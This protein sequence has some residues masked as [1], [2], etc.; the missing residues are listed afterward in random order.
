MSDEELDSVAIMGLEIAG[1][2]VSEVYSPGR[3]CALASSF[4][5]KPGI[6]AS[7]TEQ[8]P[9]GSYWDFERDEDVREWF[10]LLERDDPF[11]LVG[12]PPCEQ[13]SQLQDLMKCKRSPEDRE[14]ALRKARRHLWVACESYKRQLARG[15]HFLHE[16]PWGAGSWEED[17][18]REVLSLSGVQLVK[19]PMCR[20]GMRPAARGG[21]SRE[22]EGYVRKEAGFMTSLPELAKVLEDQCENAIKG[23]EREWHRRVHLIG[24]TAAAEQVYPP[25]MVRAVL[26]A[27]KRAMLR[28]GHVSAVD[29]HGGGPV[30][31]KPLVD[32]EY[33]TAWDDV[34][35]GA[36]DPEKVKKARRAELDWLHQQQ[37]YIRRTIAECM[38]VTGKPPIKLLWIDTNKGDDENENYRSRLV[39]RE[40]KLK[41][42][43]DQGRVLPASALFSAMPPLEAVKILGAKMI[44]DGVSKRGKKLQM[45][46][47]DVSRAHF[48]GE[49][50]RDIYVELPDEEK[51]GVDCAYLLKSWY[52]TQDASAIFQQDYTGHLEKHEFQR[53]VSNPAVFYNRDLD[54]RMLVHGDD[55]GALGDGDALDRMDEI[56]RERY[57][58]KV[59]GR[60]DFDDPGSRETVFLNRVLRLVGHPDRGDQAMEI[61]ADPR[62]AEIVIAELGLNDPKVK[63]VDTPEVKQKGDMFERTRSRRLLG[64]EITHFRSLTMRL[65]YLSADRADLGNAIKNVAKRMA[66]PREIDMQSLKRIGRYLKK[67][68]RVVQTYRR[69][70]TK[71]VHSL[72]VSVTRD[73]KSTETE[74]DINDV[75]V[76]V[77]SD[78]AGDTET[79]RST[80]G[81]VVFYNGHAVKH[82]C[83]LLQTIGLSSAENEYYAI[84]AGACTGLGVQSLLKDWGLHEDLVVETDAS[85]ALSFASRRGLGKL[86]HIQTRYLWTQERIAAKHLKVR[87][88]HTKRNH[89]DLLT[90]PLTAAEINRHMAGMSQE[91]RE[92]RAQSGKK[93]L[94]S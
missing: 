24:G 91:F 47:W 61:E 68:P 60:L 39:V 75:E 53:G 34:N 14:T 82:S 15:R 72:V 33:W 69:Q 80:V 25:R 59:S 35:G 56:L 23:R 46:F 1:V 21:P 78:N 55:F 66:D 89:S 5:L 17:V 76:M 83:N 93:V 40:K 79:R 28:D 26:G 7:I 88:V 2:G 85:A 49:A 16:H 11:L 73:R 10:D 51:N 90:K 57:S 9:D 64:P 92:G 32:E 31:I 6:C 42:A 48:Y 19:G 52:G 44:Q 8:K 50:Q 18:V 86:K 27:L 20:W 13:F 29:C 87:K 77:D 43:G 37:V 81:Q 45:R 94:G 30:P 38:K 58:L 36:L 3:Y 74:E 22:V 70:K 54:I 62:H 12:I 41:A 71:E 4:G 65:A 84:S 67:R 63:T